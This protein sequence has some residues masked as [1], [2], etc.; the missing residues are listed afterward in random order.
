MIEFAWVE[1]VLEEEGEEE[2][3]DTEGDFFRNLIAPSNSYQVRIHTLSPGA[4]SKREKF[5]IMHVLAD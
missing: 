5:V 4:S 2:E 1:D 3:E